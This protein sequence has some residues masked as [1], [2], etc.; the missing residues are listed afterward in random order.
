MPGSVANASPVTVLPRMLCIA[1]ACSRDYAMIG[2]DYANGESQR[3]LLVASSRK[4]WRQSLRLAPAALV[5]LRN[6][7]EARRGNLEPFY[8]YDPYDVAPVGSNW[9]GSGS[10]ATGRYTVRFVGGWSQETGIARS[11]AS[12][13]LIEI[14]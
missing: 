1:F 3:S 13:E 14:T 8:Y 12:L 11:N 9:D 2:N 5:A 10:S 4:A 7:F 6:F